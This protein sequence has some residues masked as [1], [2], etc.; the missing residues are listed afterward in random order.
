MYLAKATHL[1]IPSPSLCP[2]VSKP[3]EAPASRDVAGT[4]TPNPSAADQV[5]RI[6]QGVLH[7]G[8]SLNEPRVSSPVAAKAVPVMKKPKPQI[9]LVHYN[10]LIT[11]KCQEI[12]DKVSDFYNSLSEFAASNGLNPADVTRHAFGGELKGAK[13]NYWKC[14]QLI[15]GMARSDRK[16]IFRLCTYRI[17]ERNY[18]SVVVWDDALSKLIGRDAPARSAG[19]SG[20]DEKA[21]DEDDEDKDEDEDGDEDED[22]EAEPDVPA[23]LSDIDFKYDPR[24]PVGLRLGKVSSDD[25]AQ[26]HI[27]KSA[28]I[29]G[30]QLEE[31]KQSLRNTVLELSST[32]STRS[33]TNARSKKAVKKITQELQHYVCPSTLIHFRI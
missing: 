7:P 1:V 27:I 31:W 5:A 30:G 10:P 11:S 32:L 12:N 3:L 6:I 8:S 13:L 21:D 2:P 15:R 26:Y 19:G 4:L 14:F 17:I 25:A 18:C 29:K 23:L 16:F 33:L 20:K 24:D 28:C 9:P 22:A